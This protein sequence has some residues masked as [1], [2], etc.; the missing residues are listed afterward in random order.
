[1]E[2]LRDALFG[3]RC[4]V[5]RREHDWSF[6]F[7]TG[8]S[9]ATSSPWRLVGPERVLVTD[10]DDGQ[11]F[12]LPEP[13]DA[14]QAANTALADVAIEAIAVAAVTADL[15]IMFAG[16]VRLEVWTGSSGYEAWQAVF[17]GPAGERSL[18]AMGGGALAI[19]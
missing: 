11:Q 14:A 8:C 6:E 10:A 16:G 4:S 18:I 17:P 9:L 1:V 7:G 5:R 3:R 13:V 15:T 2:E 12:G 19:L